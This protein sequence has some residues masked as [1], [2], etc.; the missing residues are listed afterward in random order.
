M[1]WRNEHASLKGPLPSGPAASPRL[2]EEAG[3]RRF[4]GAN[5]YMSTVI[6]PP[7]PLVVVVAALWVWVD[8]PYASRDPWSG[9]A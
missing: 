9:E 1:D 8:P 6:H 3:R 2:R 4:C 7:F 5:I